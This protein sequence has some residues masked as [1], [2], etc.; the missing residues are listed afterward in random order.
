MAQPVAGSFSEAYPEPAS[1]VAELFVRRVQQTPAAPALMAPTDPGW[2]TFTWGEVD[3]QVRQVAAGLIAL[4]VQSEERVAIAA[5]TSYDWI[6]ADLAI[7]LSGAATTTVY[8]STGPEDT[9]YILADSGTVVVFA[10]DDNQI[11]KLRDQRAALPALRKVITFSGTADGDWVV[12][13]DDVAKQGIELL[14]A[15]PTAVDDRIGAIRPDSLAT[16]IYTSGTTGKPKGVQLLHSNWTYEAAAVEALDI[17]SI[18]DVQF[19]WLPLAHSFGKVL[20]AIMLQ[21]G[22]VTAVDGRVPKIVENLSTV[23]PT[24][25]AAVPRIFEKVHA[26]VTGD[27]QHE[28]GAKQQIF[29]WAFSVGTKAADLREHGK[30]PNAVLAAQLLVADRLVFSKIKQG[31]GGRVRYFVSG[32]AGLSTDIN[33]WFR[34]AGM[35]ILEGYGLTETSAATTLNRPGNVGIGTVGEPF[36]G[37]EIRLADDGEILVS[38]PGVMRGYHNL[39]DAT[40]ETLIDIDGVRWFKT[41]DIGQIDSRGRVKIT[42]RKKDLVKTSGGKFIAPS[43]IESHFKSISKVASYIVIEAADRNFV[44]ALVA[45]DPESGPAWAKKVG[46]PADYN[47]LLSSDVLINHLRDDI[48]TLNSSLNKWETVRKFTILPSDLTVE[49][50]ELTPSLK[51]KRKVVSERYRDLIDAMYK[52]TGGT[53]VA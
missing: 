15:Q 46:A 17:V 20:E 21:V 11:A 34:A 19:L 23:R 53:D 12:S 24:F 42:D 5:N 32:S 26:K 2:K 27:I 3:T 51:V 45:I 28:G 40:A 37:S 39:D 4:G 35:A 33:T 36:A 1:S 52:G 22:F 13:L 38:G 9:A 30:T 47:A 41:G 18:D 10:E 16:L 29:N 50:G 48:K 14:K 44:S 6:I 31:L 8:P 25:M 49:S 43:A 7:M